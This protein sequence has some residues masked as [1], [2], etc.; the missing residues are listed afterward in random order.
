MKRTEAALF[1][2]P[3]GFVRYALSGYEDLMKLLLSLAALLF[4]AG[5]THADM[6][7][8]Q[9][10]DGAGQSGEMTMKIGEDKVR[11]D[12][13]P[14]VSTITD[15]KT[16]DVTTLMHAQ[17]SY[18]VMTAA[19]TKAMFA[20]MSKLMEQSDASASPAAPKAS[21]KTDKINGWNAAEYTFSNGMMKASY[22]I[23]SDFPN[24]KAVTD[25]LAKFRKG[26]LADMTKAFAPDLS[27]LPGVPVKTEVEVNGQKIVTEMV[28]AK[29]ETVDP[30][31]YQVPTGYSEMKMPAM[32]QQ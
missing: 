20:K 23:S 7:I 5:L 27:G 24:A 15:I 9:K 22:W 3:I 18:L 12:V 25:A 8:V 21:G 32:P 4:A 31:V 30:S 14:Q 26:G 19:T 29:D 1:P 6:V 28:S 13:S 17:K 16:G 10:V 11:A 2:S